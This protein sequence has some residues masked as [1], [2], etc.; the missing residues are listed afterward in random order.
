M[1]EKEHADT[2]H[3]NP[4]VAPLASKKS[5]SEEEILVGRKRDFT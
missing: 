4:G 1:T 2:D 3:K 5:I